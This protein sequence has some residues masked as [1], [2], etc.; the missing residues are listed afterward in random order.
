MTRG[1][2]V[3]RVTDTFLGIIRVELERS[4][5]F[6]LMVS[7]SFPG[8]IAISRVRSFQAIAIGAQTE[9]T[10]SQMWIDSSGSEFE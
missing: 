7:V 8:S 1:W 4:P 9:G 5:R 3:P 6:P 2:D 10:E